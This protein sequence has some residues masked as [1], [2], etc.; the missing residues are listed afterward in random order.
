MNTYFSNCKS[1]EEAKRLYHKLAMANHPDL[2]GDLETMKQIN[3]EYDIIAE[4]LANIHESAT[5]D[6]YT[7]ETENTEIPADFRNMINNL[8]HMEGII[9]EL[10]GKWIWVTGNTYQHKDNIKKMGF[11]YASTKKA[12]FWHNPED[13]TVN[14]KKM[15]LEDIK[16]KY[17][18]TSFQTNSRMAIA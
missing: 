13:S 6:T 5:G 18:C 4:R 8:I 10:V 3:N 11:K 9:V 16:T 14:R 7:A 2:G 1:I 17:G 15:S 12:W